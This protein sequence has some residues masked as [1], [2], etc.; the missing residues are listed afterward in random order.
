MMITH[1][2][3]FNFISIF[4]ISALLVALV[5]F[6]PAGTAQAACGTT[7]VVQ[8]GDTI[9]EIAQNCG[10]TITAIARA[11]PNI[12]DLSLIYPGQTILL[13]GAVTIIP[14]TGQE[15]YIVKPRDN[16]S[17]IAANFGVSLDALTEAN[18]GIADPSLIYTGQRILIPNTT[19]GIP[20]TGG[21]P[22]IQ[23]DQTAGPAGT[24]VYVNGANFPA[25]IGVNINL[26]Q[27][28]TSLNSVLAVETG[29]D[30]RFT[31]A[32][33]IPSTAI[34][35]TTWMVQAY[36]EAAGGI[37]TNAYYNVQSVAPGNIYTVRPGDTLGEIAAR[38]GTSLN[39]LLNANPNISDPNL[40][41]T[42]EQIVI[43]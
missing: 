28:G 4:V 30:G 39:A 35:G 41:Y 24:V 5:G 21:I 31:V 43:P 13:P 8:S 26:G 3:R 37:V 2:R 7:Y 16:M 23:L 17:Q 11:N 10:T 1:N 25:N 19:P 9:G 29:F 27:E 12:T 6:L 42:G 34:P 33:T 20:N 40:I 14:N 36:T 38:F 18:P 22:S 15:V 32:V